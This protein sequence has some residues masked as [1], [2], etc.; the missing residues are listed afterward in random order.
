MAT[1]RGPGF[2]PQSEYEQAT[3]ELLAR[4]EG[5]VDRDSFRAVWLLHQAAD[6][7][8][9]FQTAEILDTYRLTWAQ[10]EVVWNLWLFGERDAGWVASAAMVSKSGL[11]TIL[12]QL[13]TRGLVSRRPD[14][15]DARRSLVRLSDEGDQTM[16]RLFQE[17]NTAEARFAAPL[18]ASE[19]QELARLLNAMLAG[20]DETL[21]P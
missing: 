7:A 15:D 21:R 4:H 8:R 16:L 20:W 2:L 6:A 13:S 19:K 9:A 12:S 1:K 14:P 11:T 5:A 3:Q 17:M 10:F 18:S